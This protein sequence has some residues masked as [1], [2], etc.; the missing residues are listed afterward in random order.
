[1]SNDLCA[2]ITDLFSR[3]SVKILDDFRDKHA[4]VSREE[5]LTAP[6]GHTREVPGSSADA[7]M[8]LPPSPTTLAL[9]LGPLQDF[10]NGDVVRDMGPWDYDPFQENEG[11]AATIP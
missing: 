8:T 1:M 6:T 5:E 10:V 7:T 11:T 2:E 4:T 9:A 3:L